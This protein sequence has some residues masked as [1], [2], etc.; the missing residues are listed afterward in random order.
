MSALQNNKKKRKDLLPNSNSV[1][2]SLACS[3]QGIFPMQK[4]YVYDLVYV[5]VFNKEGHGECNQS[6]F[7]FVGAMTAGSASAGS[8]LAVA[9]AA[10][11][12]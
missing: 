2:F 7:S 11:G 6:R 5:Q 3:L 9:A 10:W 1:A 12:W 8:W 4:Y